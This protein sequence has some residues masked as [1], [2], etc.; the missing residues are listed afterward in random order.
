MITDQAKVVS[1]VIDT[2]DDFIP[3]VVKVFGCLHQHVDT[4]FHVPTRHDQTK[5]SRGL[6]LL[7]L[8]SYYKQRVLVALQEVQVA[9]V[10]QQAIV[11]TKKVSSRL[12][13]L[14]SLA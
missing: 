11:V 10:L 5:G 6:P 1:Y 13:V 2:Q 9:I 8:R 4:F 12:G 3:L 7:I 14:P